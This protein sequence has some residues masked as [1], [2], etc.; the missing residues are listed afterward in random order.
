[1]KYRISSIVS[2]TSQHK[3]IIENYFFMTA[4]QAINSLFGILIYPFVIRKLGAESYG[5]YVFS[6]SLVGYFTSLIS[7]GFNL[8]A[9]KLIAQ[10]QDS[11]EVKS[12]IMSGVLTA[13]FYITLLSSFILAVLIIS[14]P[15][16]NKHW[17]IYFLS[18]FL[19]L[20]EILFPTWFFQ[21]IQKM[22]II[23][24]LQV[25]F[26]FMTLPLIYFLIKTPDD[27]WIYALIM[28]STSILVGVSATIILRTKENIIFKWQSFKELKPLM[29]ESLPFFFTS[30]AE[31]LKE[32]SAN[33]I[34]GIFFGMRDVAI[35]DLANKII[36][37]PRVI[38]S[39]ING[40]I[41]PQIAKKHQPQIVKKIIRYEYFLSFFIIALIILLGKW[42]I[43]FL[44][45]NMMLDAYPI[46]IIMSITICV[47]LAVGCYIYFIFIPLKKYYLV[48]KNQIVALLSFFAFCFIGLMITNHI[49]VLAIALSASGV[50]E[51]FYCRYMIKKHHLL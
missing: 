49:I 33:L 9:T 40:A 37:I 34:I 51:I 38:T 19:M 3:K 50:T 23:T 39:S 11:I 31:S 25:A 6:M 10:N 5:L 12:K 15:S 32:Q 4:L 27:C 44:G 22:K 2:F 1:M 16:L 43:L 18:S 28:S 30:I 24:N 36:F 29:H 45:G 47:W 13:K 8:P 35:Y 17:L 14:I 7:F 41:F 26:R 21:G 48:T 42:V 20:S 46:S